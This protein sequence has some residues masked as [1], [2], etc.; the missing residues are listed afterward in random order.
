MHKPAV[1]LVPTEGA[2]RI[3]GDLV[4]RTEQPWLRI[5][6]AETW[7]GQWIRLRYRSSFFDD[8]VRPLLR[9]ETAT[10]DASY[11]ALNGPVLGSGEA[12]VRVPN[13]TVSVSI[14]PVAKAGRFDFVI[15]AIEAVPRTSLFADGLRREPAWAL[16]A[17]GAR[18]IQARQEA[19]QDLKFAIGATS[20]EDYD[21]WHR[22]L[23]R[24]L[25]L[26]GIDSPRSDWRM[27]SH[28]RL[29]MALS[30]SD[31]DRIDATLASLRAQAYQ[32]W[33]LH[34]LIDP[35][36]DGDEVAKYRAA[37]RGDPRLAEISPHTTIEDLRLAPDDRVAVIDAGDTMPDHALA[38]VVETIANDPATAI[39]YGDEDAVASDGALHSPLFKPNWSPAFQAA[40][41]YL[42]RLTCIRSADLVR[43]GCAM[44]EQLIAGGQD[45][46][47]SVANLDG[48]QKVV[49]VR[50]ILYRRRRERGEPSAPP[51][52]RMPAVA[53][54]IA[55]V[56]AW[57]TVTVIV[58]S[59]DRAG[60]LR[61]CIEGLKETTDYPSFDVIVVDNGSVDSDAIALLEEIEGDRHITVLRVPG[62]FNYSALCNHGAAKTNADVLVLLNNDVAMIEPGW[63][64]SL[65]AWAVRGDV[66]AVGAKLLYPN[67]KIQH[68]GI[69][70]GSGGRAGHLYKG[71][72]GD[73][74]GYL[75]Q[76][77]VAHEVAAV[78]GACLAVARSKFEAVGGFDAANLP[79]DLND[80]DLCLRLSE[81]GW[82][83]I[84]APD[85][86]LTHVEGGSRRHTLHPAKTYGA[87]RRYFIRRW[88][89]VIRD[90]PYFHPA[91]SLFSHRPALA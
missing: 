76:L 58:P 40:N 72:P 75:H 87:E 20:F 8:P 60:Y 71:A 79:V 69:V 47:N 80:V 6:D 9:F 88:A 27:A 2:E 25:D 31:G 34:A 84:W 70:V 61:R 59:R 5:V 50:R 45:V 13:G 83:A 39:A 51:Q 73:E 43:A 42:G 78:T 64:K 7:R 63:L 32:R 16:V 36:S 91:L 57:P 74:P 89:R 90:D 85:A 48:E 11:H 56:Q 33:T 55:S 49:H 21:S 77:Q 53:T 41:P 66:G 3:G 67:G 12:I 62:P 17:A 65:A 1:N 46:V 10:A 15:D 44:P 29:L 68:A 30:A 82:R 24:P 22:G 38:V 28:I 14:S 19:Q 86:V 18:L 35:Q 4:A 23:A 26:D 52:S 54:N 37:M 81:R